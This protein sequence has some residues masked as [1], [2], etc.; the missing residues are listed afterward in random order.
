MESDLD[1]LCYKIDSNRCCIWSCKIPSRLFHESRWPKKASER[2]LLSRFPV[3]FGT[4]AAGCRA[5]PGRSPSRVA[6]SLAALSDTPH[7]CSSSRCPAPSSSSKNHAV[8]LRKLVASAICRS[9][10]LRCT[11]SF[12]ILPSQNGANP[13][14]NRLHSILIDWTTPPSASQGRMHGRQIRSM[15]AAVAWV[16][17]ANEPSYHRDGCV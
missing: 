16:Q 13:F 3:W 11:Y 10:A 9:S 17:L 7:A 6:D 12:P 1:V 4:H 5:V 2:R 8:A 14:S 15:A